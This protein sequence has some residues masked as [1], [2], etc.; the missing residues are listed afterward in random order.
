M[1]L[2]LHQ[3]DLRYEKLRPRKPEAERKL[4]ASLA[5]IGQ[6]V[7]VVVVRSDVPEQLI[8]VDGYKRVRALQP[9]RA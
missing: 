2:E 1:N 9:T 8:L 5:E 3:I 7:P 6:Q 4:A